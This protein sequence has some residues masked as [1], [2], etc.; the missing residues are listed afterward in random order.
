VYKIKNPNRFDDTDDL[1]GVRLAVWKRLIQKKRVL[2]KPCHLAMSAMV[3]IAW[4]SKELTT[5]S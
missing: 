2:S 5:W 3:K 4:K 1:W